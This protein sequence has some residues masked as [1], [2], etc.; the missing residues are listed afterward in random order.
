MC[1]VAS[2]GPRLL[3]VAARYADGWNTAWHSDT[4][5]VKEGYEQIKE[6]CAAVGRD[7]TS[8]ALTAGIRVRL[9]S[10]GEDTRAAPVLSGSAED[11]A[12]SLQSFA[13]V[14]VTHLIVAL[15]PKGLAGIEQFARILE[16]LHQ[17]RRENV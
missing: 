15:E 3:H 12:G 17:E 4:A 10:A 8:I 13:E 11:I 1:Q 2:T 7:P 16:L 5:A 9:L 14:G 6:A